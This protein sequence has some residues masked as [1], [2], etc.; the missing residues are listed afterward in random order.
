MAGSL[1]GRLVHDLPGPGIVLP[2]EV[3]AGE[4]LPDPAAVARAAGRMQ[5]VALPQ[6]L[7][8]VFSQLFFWNNFMGFSVI[9]NHLGMQRAFQ[10]WPLGAKFL[11]L[12]Q[13]SFGAGVVAIEI[14]GVVSTLFLMAWLGLPLCPQG[15]HCCLEPGAERTCRKVGDIFEADVH[16]DAC[17]HDSG[18]SKLCQPHSVAASCSLPWQFHL[19]TRPC[20]RACIPIDGYALPEQ[21]RALWHG[22]Q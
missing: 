21:L 9:K 18:G 10:R 6:P 11:G 1:H 17:E 19:Q 4:P 14:A 3:V 2:D 20:C 7:L 12:L 22:G 13:M 15:A 5:R 8:S 16:R